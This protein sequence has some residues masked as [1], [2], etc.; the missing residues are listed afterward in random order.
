MTSKRA[1]A[2]L[3]IL[4]SFAAFQPL[5]AVADYSKRV[6]GGEDQANGCPVA[7]DIMLGC[8]P[9]EEQIAAA[10]C[11]IVSNGQRKILDYHID[12]QGSHEG[13]KC[14]Y[15]WYLVTCFTPK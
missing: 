7:K 12:R 11:T 5:P 10:A 15:A 2:S 6:C 14:G 8:N 3:I 9:T 13:G 1:C 4:L